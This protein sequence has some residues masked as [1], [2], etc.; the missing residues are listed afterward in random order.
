MKLINPLIILRI[1]STILLIAALSFLPSVP[2]AYIYGESP[3]PFLWSALITAIPWIILRIATRNAPLH[4]MNIRDGFMVVTLSWIIFAIAG[5]IPY[6][7]SGTVPAFTD[8]FF[9]ATSGFTTTG[10]TIMNDVEIL[11]HSILFWRSF[12]HWIGGLGI[13][14]LVIIIL[15]SLKISGQQLFTMESS[16]KEK[17]LPKTKAVGFRL[18]FVY[19]GLTIAEVV[20]LN[21]GDMTLF[22]SICHS[23][24]TVATGGFS[25]R[26]ASLTN[27]SSYSQYIVAIFMFLSGVS[28]V[29]YYYIV[30]LRFD[31]VRKNEE[32]WFYTGTVLFAGM[33]AAAILLFQAGRSPETAFREGF[34]QVISFITTTGF[35]TTDYLYWPAASIILLFVLFFAGASTGSSTG[36]IKMARHLLAIKNVK[37]SFTKM[38]HPNI[39]TPIRMNGKPVPEKTS[40]TVLSF[41]ALYLFIFV[42]GTIIVTL[43]GLDL[44]TAASATASCLGNVGPGL[45]QIGPMFNYS[46]LPETSKFIFGLLMITGRLEIITVIALFSKS[47]WRL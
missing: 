27:Y 31:K 15:P 1:L 37:G 30:K 26:N 41:I 22:D 7:I 14:V 8:A 12:T 23:F 28:F 11:P 6:L 20:L 38:L 44:V 9:E 10:A 4:E 17:I 32:L 2:V 25:T 34:F 42:A 47:F 33:T 19:F 21:L 13:I 39:I 46:A 16:L 45:G 36:S 18:M 24:G 35:I 43:T 5:A 3:G 40:I 29:I